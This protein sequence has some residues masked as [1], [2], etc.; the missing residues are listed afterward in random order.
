MPKEVT[1]TRAKKESKWNPD[2]PVL[3]GQLAVE[4]DESQKK[5]DFQRYV[6]LAQN[7]LVLTLQHVPL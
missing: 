1:L 3:L 7:I 2:F 6:Y 5:L 4:E